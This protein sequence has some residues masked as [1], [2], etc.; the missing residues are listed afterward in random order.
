MSPMASLLLTP[1]LPTFRSP[2]IP[3][4]TLSPRRTPSSFLFISAGRHAVAG[5]RFLATTFA[6]VESNT[7]SSRDEEE[8][9]L[10]LLQELSRC[11]YLPLDFLS[12]LPG[13]LRLDLNDAAFDLANGPVLDECGKEVGELFL[14]LSRA[15]EQADTMTSNSIASKLPSLHGY[16]T[17]DVKPAIG[18]RLLSVGRRFEAM[19]Q[20]EQGELQ[21]ISRAMIKIGKLLSTGPALQTEKSPKKETKTFKFGELQVALT[22]EKANIGAA[23]AFAFG[24]LSWELSQGIQ[25]IPE[26]SFQYAN[27][28]ALMLAKSLRGSLLVIGYSSTLLSAFACVGLLLLGQQLSSEKSK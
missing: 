15:W 10:P 25:N 8:P 28:N 12:K 7:S 19:G 22:P 20:Y 23:I 17:S 4:I 27:D 11:L 14:N 13:D 3:T 9:I 21:R 2:S 24:F 18:K 26:S 5:A 1:S 16:L 6:L